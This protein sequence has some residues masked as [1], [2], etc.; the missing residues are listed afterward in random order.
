MLAEDR[1]DR[2][3]AELVP[4]SIRNIHIPTDKLNLV[5]ITNIVCL[6]SVDSQTLSASIYGTEYSVEYSVLPQKKMR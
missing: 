4:K 2:L 3:I 5:Q 1:L 6:E